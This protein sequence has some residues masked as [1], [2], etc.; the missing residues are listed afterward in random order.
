[1]FRAIAL[2][3]MRNTRPPSAC[4]RRVTSEPREPPLHAHHSAIRR[5]IHQILRWAALWDEDK[6]RRCRETCS[7]G[8][9]H[10][11]SPEGCFSHRNALHTEQHVDWNTLCRE[12]EQTSVEYNVSGMFPVSLIRIECSEAGLCARTP[13]VTNH[14][15]IYELSSLHASMYFRKKRVFLLVGSKF[16][17]LIFWQSTFI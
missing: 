2:G 9:N 14:R 7:A 17:D 10:H 15:S 4:I 1:M 13:T 11:L 8:V 12:K 3:V 5:E 16:P 6:R